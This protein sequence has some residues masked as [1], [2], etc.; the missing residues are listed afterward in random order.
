MTKDGTT[1]RENLMKHVKTQRNK[2][3]LT[4]LENLSYIYSH[5]VNGTLLLVK[6]NTCLRS[7]VLCLMS[8][9]N[10]RLHLFRNCDSF[11]IKKFI[12][13]D[14][15]LSFLFAVNEAL[16]LVMV[17]VFN[18]TFNDT[19]NATFNDTFNGRIREIL[20]F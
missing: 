8:A 18:A 14:R 11:A 7:Y 16:V 1:K 9:I 19:F 13:L 5:K 20:G 15:V 4:D 2:R 12:Q 3:A 17:M 10:L 6:P